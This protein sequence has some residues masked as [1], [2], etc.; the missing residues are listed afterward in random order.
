MKRYISRRPKVGIWGRSLWDSYAA[1]INKRIKAVFDKMERKG[2]SFERMAK[3]SGVSATTIHNLWHGHVMVPTTGT[4]YKLEL[5]V[6]II[7]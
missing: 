1:H 2:W 4:I 5:C 7:K 6:G 3:E